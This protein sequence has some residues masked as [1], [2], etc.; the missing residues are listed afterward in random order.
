[1]AIDGCNHRS[2]IVVSL[3][4]IRF[5]DRYNPNSCMTEVCGRWKD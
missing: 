5:R 3:W 2:L 1:V 4:L